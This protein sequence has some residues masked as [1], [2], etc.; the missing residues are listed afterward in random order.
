MELSDDVLNEAELE[1][2]GNI[3]VATC[4][5]LLAKLRSGEWTASGVPPG[6]AIVQNPVPEWWQ[7]P[8][9]LTPWANRAEW[10]GL[11]LE[12]VM[13]DGPGAGARPAK[14]RAP[15]DMAV[16]KW[17]HDRC[18]RHLRQTGTVLN[19]DPAIL[20]CRKATGATAQQASD[21]YR[22]LPSEIK[23]SRGVLKD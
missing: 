4:D 9:N 15:S 2:L 16:R 7:R 8:I 19:R 13:V 11:L 21:A 22:E 14:K 23:R 20:E 5:A 12:G 18:E 10:N 17:M 3:E 6:S 1:R